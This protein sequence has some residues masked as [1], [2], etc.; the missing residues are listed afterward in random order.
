[1]RPSARRLTVPERERIVA[2]KIYIRD[3]Y[4]Y[5]REREK[6]RVMHTR[7]VLLGSYIGNFF[8]GRNLIG[9]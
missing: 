2:H 7:R 6:E 5:M 1:L 8:G 9:A 3:S 4:I